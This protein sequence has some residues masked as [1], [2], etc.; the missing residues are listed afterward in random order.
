MKKSLKTLCQFVIFFGVVFGLIVTTTPARASNGLLTISSG[1]ISLGMGG[2]GV[3]KP[4]DSNA[5]RMN[6][7]GMPDIV[8]QTDLNFTVAFPDN[9]MGSS[10]APAG[11]PTA[12]NVSGTDDAAFFPAGSIVFKAFSDRL[13]LGVG[14]LPVAGFQVEFPVSRFSNAIT[15]NLYDRTGRFGFIR[16]SPAFGF[17]ILDNLN[18]GGS[19]D[20]NYSFFSTDSATL[21]LG[22]PET[23]GLNRFDSA[24]GVSGRLGV[25]YAPIDMLQI[26]AVWV[27]RS[28]MQAFDRYTDLIPTGLDMPMQVAFGLAFM[29]LKGFTLATDFR[30]INWSSGF[31]GTSMAAGGL[32][33]RDQY[34]FAGGLNYDFDPQFGIPIAFRLGY[35]YG[36]SPITPT[37][38]FR[39]LLIPTVVEHHL[40]VGLGMNLG[41]HIGFDAAYIREFAN[42]V[43]DNG[44]GNPTG[45]GSF[46]GT[47]VNAFS[48]GVRG[49]WGKKQP[50]EP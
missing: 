16:I 32:Q 29:P 24:L 41:E 10:L 2:A 23:G 28:H 18:V 27:S 39:N 4:L 40:T 11:N 17:K 13:A 36:R 31:L 38:A 22:F 19:F 9:K 30:W 15:N 1:P 5:I 3:A 35:N 6:P 33:W 43:T 21:A 14:A 7:A 48:V 45:A 20:I 42:T 44:S 50:L 47:S 46:T 12:V 37:N 8:N 49:S 34:V 25:T 26:G